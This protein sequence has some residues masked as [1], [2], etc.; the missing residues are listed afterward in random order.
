MMVIIIIK[1]LYFFL[2]AYCANMAP[3][4]AYALK[5]PWGQPVSARLFGEHKTYRGFVAGFLMAL[6]VICI[7][8]ILFQKNVFVTI[9][10]LDYNTISIFLYAFAF[11]VGA[12]TGDLVKSFFKR[13]LGKN[14]GAMWF[15][16]DQLD[17]VFGA[18]IFLYPFYQTPKEIVTILLI[19]TP[20]LHLP[21]NILGYFLGLKQVWW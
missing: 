15:P 3:V 1:A 10:I 18:L 2:P 19:I 14:P 4:F 13:R 11:G 6:F 20:I 9:S 12:I 7:Q 17:F 21:L 16:F 5:L 8:K